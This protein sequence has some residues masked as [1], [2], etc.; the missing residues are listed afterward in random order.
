MTL[1]RQLILI[2][3]V[4]LTMIGV[5][6]L[7]NSIFD[8]FLMVLFG[9]IGY[10]MR[11]YGYSV[12]G[13]SIAVILGNGLEA[14]LR[15]GLLLVRWKLVGFRDAP[16]DCVDPRRFLRFPHLCNDRHD[17]PGTQRRG[18]PPASGSGAPRENVQTHRPVQKLIVPAMRWDAIGRRSSLRSRKESFPAQPP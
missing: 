9:V 3:C 4:A 17:P 14:N 2:G 13:A 15:R 16:V 1:D 7:N 6:T 18:H 10:F 11:R 8:V 12:A 5:F